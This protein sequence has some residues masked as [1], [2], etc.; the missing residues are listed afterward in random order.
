VPTADNLKDVSVAVK[1]QAINIEP[2]RPYLKIAYALRAS[3]KPIKGVSSAEDLF[4]PHRKKTS[5]Q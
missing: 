5:S 3:K 4:I 1:F 2:F